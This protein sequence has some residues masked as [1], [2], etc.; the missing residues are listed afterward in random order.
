MTNTTA[1]TL[2]DYISDRWAADAHERRAR[3]DEMNY[4]NRL[5]WANVMRA[6][7]AALDTLVARR[8]AQGLNVGPHFAASR[9]RTIY[10]AVMGGTGDHLRYVLA[11]MVD[12]GEADI[13]APLLRRMW[14]DY[15]V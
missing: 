15:R 1:P 4:R 5:R 2:P 7:P 6:W 3:L 10:S 11:E 8:H 12:E 14:T 13:M 9:L